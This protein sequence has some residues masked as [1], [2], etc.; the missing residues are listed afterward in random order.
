MYLD[1]RRNSLWVVHTGIQLRRVHVGHFIMEELK[2]LA[3]LGCAFF[4]TVVLGQISSRIFSV[5]DF[6]FFGIRQASIAAILNFP[7]WKSYSSLE[8]QK[9]KDGTRRTYRSLLSKSLS[10][11]PISVNH[12][13]RRNWP[14][15]AKRKSTASP[16]SK[17]ESSHLSYSSSS[18]KLAPV[19]H[20]SAYENLF[21]MFLDHLIHEL[22]TEN[23]LFFIEVGIWQVKMGL[24]SSVS[25][26][27]Q[28]R[29][30]RY[31]MSMKVRSSSCVVAFAGNSSNS[32][33]LHFFE[34][35]VPL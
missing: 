3:L 5:E 28:N 30:A 2:I 34:Y 32:G 26:Y 11:S 14:A 18:L 25:L 24:P 16:R 21:F 31:S 15:A 22:S 17:S 8:E 23:I 6:L 27:E 33:A 9:R 35:C 4:I 10:K 13:V 1:Y 19:L 12:Y 20:D 29:R 7:V